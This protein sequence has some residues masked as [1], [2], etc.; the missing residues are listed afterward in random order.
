MRKIDM[1][2]SFKDFT[3]KQAIQMSN[4]SQNRC[5]DEINAMKRRTHHFGREAGRM[6]LRSVAGS[7][8]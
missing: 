8:W 1:V 4:K 2:G 3:N 5:L 7:H 6:T